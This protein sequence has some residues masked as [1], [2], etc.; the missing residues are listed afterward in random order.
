MLDPT[1]AMDTLA[2]LHDMGVWISIDDFGK[3]YSSL[4]YLKRLPAHQI[5]IDRSFVMDMA[6]SDDDAFIVRSVID[7]GHSLGLRVVAEGIENQKTWDLLAHMGCDVA[8]GYHLSRPLPPLEL[9]HWM[10]ASEGELRGV[11]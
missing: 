8:Q 9:Q 7:L 3:G 2:Q 11:S 1:R 5:K 4:S 6:D 10:Y